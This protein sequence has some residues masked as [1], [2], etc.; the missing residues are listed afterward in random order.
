MAP[1]PGGPKTKTHKKTSCQSKKQ[2]RPSTALPLQLSTPH[3]MDLGHRFLTSF[4]QLMMGEKQKT[5]ST[6]WDVQNPPLLHPRSLTNRPWKMGGC[7]TSFLLG[8]PIFRGYV[9]LR[10]GSRIMCLLVGAGY[11][12]STCS[13]SYIFGIMIMTIIK[14]DGPQIHDIQLVRF[15]IVT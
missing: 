1:P 12:P 14:P 9:Q 10:E 4:D 5:S 15:H 3:R 8:R 6:N 2:W 13:M 11:L 7:K